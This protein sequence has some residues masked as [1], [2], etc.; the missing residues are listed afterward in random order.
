MVNSCTWKGELMKTKILVGIFVLLFLAAC[1]QQ[2]E[3]PVQKTEE[4][5]KIGAA[6]PLTG[7]ASPYGQNARQGIDLAVEEINAAGGIDGRQIE[8]I[9]EDDATGE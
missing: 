1:A 6:L 9:Y 4:P 2:A 7:V 5:I 8:I 3:I